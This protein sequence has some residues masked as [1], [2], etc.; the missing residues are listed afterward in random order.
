MPIDA[1]HD[2]FVAWV[3][4]AGLLALACLFVVGLVAWIAKGFGSVPAVLLRAQKRLGLEM[5]VLDLLVFAV[6]FG[7]FTIH[8]GG[9]QVVNVGFDDD[10][11]LV[12]LYANYTNGTTAIEVYFTGSGV[13]VSTP[14][15]VRNSP[16]EEWRELLKYNATITTDFTTNCLAF[17]TLGDATTNL[18]WY[19]GYNTP[20]VIVETTGIE[21]VSH[22]ATSRSVEFAWSCDDPRATVFEVQRRHPGD[23]QWET[24]VT[25]SAT[26][27]R[28]DG[29]TIGESWEYRVVST[30]TMEEGGQ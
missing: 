8:G 10:I 11:D 16:T 19:V 6:F 15:S 25:T 12:G 21:F 2:A 4:A 9:K 30:Y 5:L 7:V 22:L 13:T 20:A 24:V 1:L 26:S 28:Y 3:T 27:Y 17:A 18:M 29:F 14:V 23:A